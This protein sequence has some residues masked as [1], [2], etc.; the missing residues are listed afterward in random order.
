MRPP[1]CQQPRLGRTQLPKLHT[2]GTLQWFV[3]AS[4][5]RWRWFAIELAPSTVKRGSDQPGYHGT[6]VVEQKRLNELV[7]IAN[8]YG[9]RVG[10]HAVGD[11]AID[12]VLDAYEYAHRAR[13]IRDRRF[14][15]IHGSLMQPDQMQRAKSLGVRVD[16][17]SVF[18]AP[19]IRSTRSIPSST[20]K[21]W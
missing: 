3:G 16:A 2:S 4:G 21:S 6:V 17:Q 13:S 9:W 20:C 19:T 5:R 14:I 12:R 7:A 8:R 11:G 15:V 18:R 1:G 10:T